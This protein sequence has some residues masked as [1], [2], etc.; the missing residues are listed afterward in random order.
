IADHPDLLVQRL[1]GAASPR[2]VP[3]WHRIGVAAGW[4]A[5]VA[6]LLGGLLGWMRRSA[7]RLRVMGR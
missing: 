2:E 3:V 5:Y 1:S 4:T 6:A 7:G